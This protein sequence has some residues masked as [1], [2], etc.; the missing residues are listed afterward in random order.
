[1]NPSYT[2]ILYFL[3][4]SSTRNISRAAERLGISQ[5]S[6]SAAMK[7]LEEVLGVELLLRSRSGIHLTKSGTEFQK[8]ARVLLLNWEQLRL[9]ISKTEFEIGGQYRIGCHPSVALYTLSY[10]L[11]DL[12]ATYPDLRVQLIH[13]LSRKITEGVI[14]FEID[15]GIVV[16]PVRNSDLIIKELCVDEVLFWRAKKYFPTQDLSSSKAVLVCDTNLL[17]VQKLIRSIELK[18][19]SFKRILESSN[20]E[21]ITDLTAAGAGIGILPRRVASKHQSSSLVSLDGELPTF[22]D[23]ICLIY[24]ADFQKSK[25]SKMIVDYIKRSVK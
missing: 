13:D 21:V 16:N 15:L 7:R 18:G 10:F 4:V 22:N 11:P 24:R 6:L 12:L 20:L 9:E 17:Q 1:M 3:E 2:D 23:R 25:A 5:P 19:F 8:K 14:S